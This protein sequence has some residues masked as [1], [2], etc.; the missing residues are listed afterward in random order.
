MKGSPPAGA[1][2]ARW[3]PRAAGPFTDQQAE[4]V[5]YLKVLAPQMCPALTQA[6]VGPHDE[7]R[8]RNETWLLEACGGVFE[9]EAAQG[10]SSL[11]PFER[12]RCCLF[13]ADY[14]MRNAGDL[15]TAADLHPTFL[16]DG[17]SAAE[18]LG[19][20]QSA[21]AFSLSPQELEERYFDLFDSIVAE[22]R[23]L[24]SASGSS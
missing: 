16:E 14:G 8:V 5:E 21:A 6:A 10:Y 9:K 17:R 15:T 23:V 4:P 1:S 22:L 11:S 20:P 18:E 24:A 19:L 7:A 12:L 13:A 2:L 3:R